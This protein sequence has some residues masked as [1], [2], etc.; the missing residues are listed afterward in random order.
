VS[1]FLPRPPT[2]PNPPPPP[3]PRAPNRSAPYL[4]PFVPL[5]VFGLPALVKARVTYRITSEDYAGDTLRIAAVPVTPA[6]LVQPSETT[7]NRRQMVVPSEVLRQIGRSISFDPGLSEALDYAATNAPGT[8]LAPR[9]HPLGALYLLFG[10]PD[11]LKYP[12]SDIWIRFRRVNKL[13]FR[14]DRWWPDSGQG[15]AR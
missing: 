15:G 2:P 7:A 9:P 4:I 13:L 11:M 10:G 8:L 5:L 14:T 12:Q 1:L 6:I 3:A